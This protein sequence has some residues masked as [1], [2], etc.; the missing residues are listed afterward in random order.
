MPTSDVIVVSATQSEAAY[1]PAD[2]QVVICGIGKVD[3][4]VAVTRAVL[5][6]KRHPTVINIGT[7]G[8]L[9]PDVAG[10]FTPSLVRNHDI[11]AAVLRSLGYPVV[12]EIEIGGGDGTT[13]ATGDSFITDPAVRDALARDA[14][15][16]DMEGFAIARACTQLGVPVR[17][18]KHISDQADESAMDWPQQVDHSAR[19]LANWL[20]DNAG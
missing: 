3:A 14:H 18:V 2:F 4:A 15:M 11:S 17:L 12:D 20:R 13:L 16:V 9:R 5:E 19:I 10:L 8:A 7:A 1:V 6:S